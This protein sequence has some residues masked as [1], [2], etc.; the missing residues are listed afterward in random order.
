MEKGKGFTIIELLVV[1]AIISILASI[2][3]PALNAARERARRIS[4]ASNLAQ[5]AKAV[6]LYYEDWKSWP[7]A[8]KVEDFSKNPGFASLAV[9]FTDYTPLSEPKVLVCPSTQQTPQPYIPMVGG[10]VGLDGLFCS[11][12]ALAGAAAVESY[13]SGGALELGGLTPEPVDMSTIRRPSKI[14]LAAD[15]KDLTPAGPGAPGSRAYQAIPSPN[16]RGDGQNA[17]YFD[18]HVEW[19]PRVPRTTDGP[20]TI[21]PNIYASNTTS[22]RAENDSYLLFYDYETETAPD[23][24]LNFGVYNEP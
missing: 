24:G 20:A 16:H 5:I 18:G 11:P 22:S 23:P 15:R 4:C 7:L 9:L 21:D 3:L 8:T 10:G 2:I 6:M 1:I 19:I 13:S 17:V 12:F 14:A